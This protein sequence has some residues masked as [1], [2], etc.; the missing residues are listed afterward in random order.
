MN[1][2]KNSYYR[3]PIVGFIMKEPLVFLNFTK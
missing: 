1:V 2:I 3:I